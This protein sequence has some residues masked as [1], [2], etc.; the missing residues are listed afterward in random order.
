VRFELPFLDVIV[1]PTGAESG[2][3]IVLDGTT[4]RIEFYNSADDLVG[5]LV[6]EP[7]AIR[8]VQYLVESPSG[9]FVE[10][11]ASAGN[12]EIDMRPPDF[13]GHTLAA[14]R[15]QSDVDTG[16]DLPFFVIGSPTIDGLQD[17]RLF[18]QG[19]A[20]DGT[21]PT[22][23]MDAGGTTI[24]ADVM[25]DGKG[26]GKGLIKRF[27][28]SSSFAAVS[29]STTSDMVVSNVPVIAG[30]W[31]EIR[32]HTPWEILGTPGRWIFD[33][34]L[35]GALLDRF[36]DTG[37]RAADD[38]GLLDA[39][40]EW[41][42]STTQA[43]DDF[44]VRLTEVSGASNLSLPAAATAKRTLTVNHIGRNQA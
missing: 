31:Y 22:I 3:R 30:D 10:L 6:S 1:L 13:V 12:A 39:S 2:T 28:T 44:A 42:A 25:I 7:D 26:I 32:A 40:I 16:P 4:G 27:E 23:N 15:I 11:F 41:Q 21:R 24:P 9:A 43:T 34:F 20:G 5:L 17:M 29:V 35:N 8:D 19:E 38:D 14:G 33:C 18:I 37:V 36:G